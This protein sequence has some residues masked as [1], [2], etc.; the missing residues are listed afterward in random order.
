MDPKKLDPQQAFDL[1][2]RRE[3]KEAP[4]SSAEKKPDVES[5]FEN[6]QPK[7]R[8]LWQRAVIAIA[9]AA[10]AAILLIAVAAFYWFVTKESKPAVVAKPP[11]EKPPAAITEDRAKEI[12]EA[13]LRAFL[14]AEDNG[15]REKYIFPDG[16]P[17]SREDFYTGRK[18]R[19]VPLW[20][21]EQME[22]SATEHGEIWFVRF[23]DL[24]RHTRVVSFQRHGDDY[25][26]HW[27]AM[28]A[29]GDMPWDEFI[30]NKPERP[31]EMRAYVRQYGGALPLGADGTRYHAFLVED[32]AGLFSELALVK[33][34]AV[35]AAELAGLPPQALHPAT[36][37]LHYGSP[38]DTVGKCL[39]ID[40]LVHLRWQRLSGDSRLQEMK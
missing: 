12:I 36:L 23:S 27:L 24:R 37:R 9:L 32:R 15:T 7:D 14:A 2:T 22:K 19:D 17:E 20:K 3:G 31:T 18:I 29:Y 21:I 39:M 13:N 30:L 38:G 6:K 28:K 40:S 26:L 11:P 5:G 8:A 25:L 10:A 34:E 1:V 4:K 16:R 35:G 33:K